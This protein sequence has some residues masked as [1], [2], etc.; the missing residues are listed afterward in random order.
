MSSISESQQLGESTIGL[1][2]YVLYGFRDSAILLYPWVLE[3]H[4]E[5]RSDA[6]ALLIVVIPY[7]YEQMDL[8]WSQRK[9]S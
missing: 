4:E 3:L 5:F 7:S 6:I 9:K 8:S 2:T 1:P